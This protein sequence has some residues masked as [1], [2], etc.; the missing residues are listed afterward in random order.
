M[1]PILRTRAIKRIPG[2]CI[3][4]ALPVLIGACA[5]GSSASMARTEARA[6]RDV[7]DHFVV[8]SPF[9][10]Q[11]SEPRPGEGCRNPMVDPRDDTRL[12]LAR[13]EVTWGDYEV[14][15]GRYGVGRRELLRLECAT[16]RVI[17][18]VR[19]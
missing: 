10:P 13:S 11:T 3:A 5:S 19:H 14:I 17:G 7:P 6:A 16:G 18:I 4:L 15:G 8:G 1:R 12:V 2:R 9:G